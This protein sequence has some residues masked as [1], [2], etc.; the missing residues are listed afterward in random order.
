MTAARAK[1][2]VTVARVARRRSHAGH[3]PARFP[4]RGRGRRVRAATV[5]GCAI[6]GRR[7]AIDGAGRGVSRRAVS[8]DA[9][10]DG[11]ADSR[12]GTRG[13]IGDVRG[14]RDRRDTRLRMRGVR[15]SRG[16]EPQRLLHGGGRAGVRRRTFSRRRFGSIFARG[17][18]R[19]PS[20]RSPWATCGRTASTS[21]R[22]RPRTERSFGWWFRRGRPRR[23]SRRCARA[24]R[25]AAS[26]PSRR[27]ASIYE[28]RRRT[29]SAPPLARY[30][31]EPRTEPSPSYVY[32]RR[33]RTIFTRCS[34]TTKTRTIPG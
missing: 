30:P 20:G 19:R 24:S 1:R 21:T 12:E 3:D 34:R 5:R 33:R 7:V 8:G 15:S 4:S 10:A 23:R 17:T 2:D 14:Q 9:G 25:E 6:G 28:A 18:P 16:D 27:D 22:D 32:I 13:G 26:R 11:G 31:S 29:F